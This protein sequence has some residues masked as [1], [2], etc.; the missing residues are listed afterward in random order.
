MGRVIEKAIRID[1]GNFEVFLNEHP[2]IKYSV[3]NGTP[4]LRLGPGVESVCFI[5]L[6]GEILCLEYSY[7]GDIIYYPRKFNF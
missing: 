6:D 3:V 2:E 1:E 7:N 4:F 5:Y